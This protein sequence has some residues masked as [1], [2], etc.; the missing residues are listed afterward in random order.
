[1]GLKGFCN[2]MWSLTPTWFIEQ[3]VILKLYNELL[4]EIFLSRVIPLSGTKDHFDF[5]CVFWGRKW[6]SK[7]CFFYHKSKGCPNGPIDKRT[8][9]LIFIPI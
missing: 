2:I 3:W 6:S 9:K 4:L 7:L 8:K 1:M 5:Q